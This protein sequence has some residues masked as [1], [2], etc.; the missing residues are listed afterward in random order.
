MT[1]A[2]VAGLGKAGLVGTAFGDAMS[3]GVSRARF[4][5]LPKAGFRRM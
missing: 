5:L 4:A 1:N 2:A 3:G